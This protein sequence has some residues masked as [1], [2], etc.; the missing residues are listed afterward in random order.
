MK[1]VLFA[2]ML[3]SL[4][5]ITFGQTKKDTTAKVPPPPPPTVTVTKFDP[6]RIVKDKPSGTHKHPK[7]ARPVPPPPAIVKDTIDK[8]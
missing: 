1:R 5:S 6:P 4:S 2:A 7:K 8:R 3:L